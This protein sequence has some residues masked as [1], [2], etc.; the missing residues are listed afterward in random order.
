MS[1]SAVVI[2]SLHMDLIARADRMPRHGE[3]VTGG[4]FAMA[5]GGKGG[6]QAIQ[7]AQCG[8][9]TTLV[10]RVGADDYGDRLKS[11]LR[12]KGVRTDRIA[13]DPE[14]TTG[15]S[16]VLAAEGDY[17]SIIAPGAASGLSR[18]D[19]LAA[20]AE[21]ARADHVALQLELDWNFIAAAIAECAA[22]GAPIMLN[23]SPAPAQPSR[24]AELAPGTIRWLVVNEVEAGA[25]ASATLA[26]VAD[27]I[28]ASEGLQAAFGVSDVIIT[29]GGE[30]AVWRHGERT[31]TQP[32]FPAEV[33]DT[34]GAGDAFLGA[35][36]AAIIDGRPADE[37]LRR[38]GAA[39]ALAVGRSGAY[40]AFP[41]AAEIDAL[42]RQEP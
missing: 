12:R 5:P 30:G 39:G 22:V 28:G 20:R 17:A 10:S 38:A 19:L 9:E 32:A 25:L 14:R 1:G 34:V 11:A 33:V 4:A 24:L 42:I 8:I 31:L 29:L 2:G 6:N 35:L 3:S 7:L 18:T 15:A 41:N 27:A 16:V 36:A 13:S 40:D 26:G 37:A 23:A 21:M